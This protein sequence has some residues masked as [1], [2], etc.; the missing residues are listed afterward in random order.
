MNAT[1]V[2][3]ATASSLPQRVQ[4]AQLWEQLQASTYIFAVF[5]LGEVDQIVVVHV[6][7]VEQVAVLLLAEIFGVNPV[8]PE[9]F[10][11]C[12]AKCLPN[13]LCDQLGLERSQRGKT[14]VNRA[15]LLGTWVLSGLWS[16]HGAPCA[17]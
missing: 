13:G 15:V 5:R 17:C 6:L 9:E 1:L 10:L 2:N 3:P 8:G 14:E 16:L 7:G 4:L 12:H 11:V